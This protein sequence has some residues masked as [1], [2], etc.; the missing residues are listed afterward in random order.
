MGGGKSGSSGGEEWR[1]Q[2]SSLLL[3]SSVTTGPLMD[4]FTDTTHCM[5]VYCK[6]ELVNKYST[7]VRNMS[8]AN[9]PRTPCYD[10]RAEN[11]KRG[12]TP[13]QQVQSR[14]KAGLSGLQ[15]DQADLQQDQ[16][17]LQQD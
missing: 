15:R 7:K 4:Y 8:A 10:R 1:Q 13:A 14:I 9:S 2:Q 16:V 6:Y 3:L 5:Y 11:W 17:D 12:K